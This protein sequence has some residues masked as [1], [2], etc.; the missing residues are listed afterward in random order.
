MAENKP[1]TIRYS[2]RHD[3][4]TQSAINH[5]FKYISAISGQMFIEDHIDPDVWKD[6]KNAIP[7]SAKLI[8]EREIES[9]WTAHLVD[10]QSSSSCAKI[11][12]DPIEKILKKLSFSAKFGPYSQEHPIPL[13]ATEPTLSKIINDFIRLLSDAGLI[14]EGARGITLWPKACKFGL[15]VSHDIDI[16]HRSVL[17]GV[18]ILLKNALPGG[19]PAIIDSAIASI[20][21]RR[22]PYDEVPEW[23]RLEGELGIKST[24]F[25]FAGNRIHANDPA[26]RLGK[27]AKSIE[28]IKS[29]GSEIALHTSIGSFNGGQILDSKSHLEKFCNTNI[30]GLR[31]H[32]LSAFFPEY[33]NEALAAGFE[34]SSSFGF[35]DDIGFVN[36]LDLPFYPYDNATGNPVNLLEIPIGIMDCGLIGN[37]NANSRDVFERG[38]ALIDETAANGGLIVLDWHQRTFYNRDYPGWLGLFLRL[39]QYAKEAGAHFT[40]MGKLVGIMKSRFGS[41]V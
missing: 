6:H 21:L 20:G 22:N 26:Y 16:A 9:R 39:V 18:R 14:A 29:R 24:F 7:K 23:L 27:L 12:Y 5:V 36:G 25:I 40:D 37:S 32:Y 15:V 13:P 3:D 11:N 35:D 1:T 8:I 34:Y 10:A 17:G 31:P 38:K 2:Y 28:L 41:Q 33:W 30:S 4:Y 19:I